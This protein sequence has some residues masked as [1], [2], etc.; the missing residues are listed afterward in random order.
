MIL[1]SVEATR[2]GTLVIEICYSV[3]GDGE[4]YNTYDGLEFFTLEDVDCFIKQ[5]QEQRAAMEKVMEGMKEK[6]GADC[7][8]K[9]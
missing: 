5:L 9:H 8:S 7:F 1:E 6:Y 4:D 3:P 2:Y